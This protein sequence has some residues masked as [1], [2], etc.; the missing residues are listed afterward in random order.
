M[1]EYRVKGSCSVHTVCACVHMYIRIQIHTYVICIYNVYC[2]YVRMYSIVESGYILRYTNSIHQKF[3]FLKINISNKRMYIH[4]DTY[5]RRNYV[6]MY[7]NFDTNST[8]VCT[9]VR[10]KNMYSCKYCTYVHTYNTH[11]VTGTRPHL[12]QSQ[13]FLCLA[14]SQLFQSVSPGWAWSSW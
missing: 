10:L 6:G 9:N 12:L 8:Y 11:I 3:Y 7:N 4:R 2:V 14:L 5:I 1:K 13:I